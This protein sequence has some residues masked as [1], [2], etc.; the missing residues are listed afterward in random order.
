MNCLQNPLDDGK[1]HGSLQ[2]HIGLYFVDKFA[3]ISI[4]VIGQAHGLVYVVMMIAHW[5][6]FFLADS[7][8]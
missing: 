4:F 5:F 1:H 2:S 3:Q 7:F 6:F 8:S